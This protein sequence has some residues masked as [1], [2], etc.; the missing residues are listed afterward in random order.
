MAADVA[1]LIGSEHLK[2]PFIKTFGRN[3]LFLE[4]ARS[5]SII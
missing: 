4:E 1:N 3:D 2:A 5:A